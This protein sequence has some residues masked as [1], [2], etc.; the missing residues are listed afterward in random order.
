MADAQ[1]NPHNAPEII[2]FK[3]HPF[4]IWILYLAYLFAFV[5]AIVITIVAL[6][7][8]DIQL[9]TSQKGLAVI[10]VCVAA[11]IG[12]IFLLMAH[13]IYW[14]SEMCV[15]DS[16]VS[17]VVQYGLFS[18]HVARLDMEKIEDV[19]SVQ[20]GIFPTMLNYGTLMIET[21]GEVENFVFL[22]CPNPNK[23]AQIIHEAR[24][25]YLDRRMY[26][27]AQVHATQLSQQGFPVQQPQMQQYP[28]QP[29][30]PQPADPN[31]QPVQQQ[32]TPQPQPIQPPAPEQP[33]QWIPPT[34]QNPPT[35]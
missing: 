17:E 26:E 13:Y 23:T 34:D 3:R 25:K 16:A 20:K 8:L 28:Q 14:R 18:R 5:A 9:S 21:A 19:T 4:G 15:T 1:L 12:A 33:Q 35:Q 22:Y 29:M 10:G 2:R 24:Q 30:Q 6:P 11:A 7:Q 27:T 31:Q 32:P